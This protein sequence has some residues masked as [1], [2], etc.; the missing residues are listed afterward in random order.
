MNKES[1]KFDTSR[2]KEVISS[3]NKNEQDELYLKN[4]SDHLFN[5]KYYL[6]ELVIGNEQSVLVQCLTF[7]KPYSQF[8]VEGMTT[9]LLVLIN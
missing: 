9:E 2:F 4:I 8:R 3:T 7:G 6:P 1:L 5:Q